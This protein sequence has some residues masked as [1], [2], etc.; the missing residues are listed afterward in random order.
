MK[1]IVFNECW[2]GTNVVGIS[3]YVYN[4]IKELDKLLE[5]VAD[6]YCVESLIPINTND[7]DLNFNNIFI[8]KRG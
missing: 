1:R 8:V 5:N 6:K 7:G 3:R 4:I 2:A